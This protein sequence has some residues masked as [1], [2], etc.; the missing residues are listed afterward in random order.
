MKLHYQWFLNSKSVGRRA[1]FFL[2][3][4]DM[5]IMSEKATGFDWK[6]KKFLTIRHAAGAEKF[7]KTK[8]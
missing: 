2:D 6:K 7:L 1:E 4:G 5:Y 8:N 3:D